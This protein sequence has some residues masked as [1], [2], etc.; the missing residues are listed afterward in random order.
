MDI[1]YCPN[2][3]LIFD[4]YLRFITYFK[5]IYFLSKENNDHLSNNCFSYVSSGYKAN[6]K[7]TDQMSNIK[8]SQYV[9]RGQPTTIVKH[10][11]FKRK[12]WYV[13][14]FLSMVIIIQQHQTNIPKC[15]LRNDL[16]S[17]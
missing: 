10:D 14:L 13:L 16:M 5:N 9:V 7:K 3:H 15:V 17:I 1:F 4:L 2:F 6:L 11:F 12:S 8:S